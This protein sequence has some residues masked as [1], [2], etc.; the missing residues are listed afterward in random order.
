[1]DMKQDDQIKQ[2][3]QEAG[4][5][6][7]GSNFADLIMTRIEEAP[8]TSI[9]YKPVISPLGIK[10]IVGGLAVFFVA[11]IFLSSGHEVAGTASWMTT[12]NALISDLMRLS[13]GLERPS[14]DLP[15]SGVNPIFGYGLCATALAFMI[16]AKTINGK[17]SW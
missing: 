14:F 15:L 8:A 3:I 5:E 4:M 12:Y 10:L 16:L 13:S 2:W 1:M 6:K 17:M 11:V 9:V 7:P